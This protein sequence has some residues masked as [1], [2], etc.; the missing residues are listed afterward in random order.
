MII[1]KSMRIR[2]QLS[3]LNQQIFPL[4]KGFL[5]HVYDDVMHN[6]KYAYLVLDL[7]PH[8]EDLYR[9]RTNIFP[10]EAPVTVYLPT[11]R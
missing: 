6:K 1:F 4:N 10:E 5:P 8:S 7:S 11:Q 9:V 3:H 2:G